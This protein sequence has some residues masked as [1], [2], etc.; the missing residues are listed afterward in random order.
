MCEKERRRG[1]GGWGG[2]RGYGCE[3]RGMGVTG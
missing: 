1:E 3:T 2:V